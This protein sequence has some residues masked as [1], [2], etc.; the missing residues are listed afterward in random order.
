MLRLDLNSGQDA[1]AGQKRLNPLSRRDWAMYLLNFVLS[2]G[3]AVVAHSME[4]RIRAI[5]YNIDHLLYAVL[6]HSQCAG[7]GNIFYIAAY[8]KLLRSIVLC[9]LTPWLAVIA[10]LL[11]A[12]VSRG[13]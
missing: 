6:P 8:E 3:G 7:A 4:D 10:H 11:A 12:H 1:L 13:I 5:Y 2:I 9:M